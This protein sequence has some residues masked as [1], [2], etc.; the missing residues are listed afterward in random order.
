MRGDNAGKAWSA[1]E[2]AELK[3]MIAQRIS[4][5]DIGIALGR[6][7]GAIEA[8][9]ARAT[10]KRNRNSSLKAKRIQRRRSG[11]AFFLS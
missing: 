11:A 5:K 2:V 9:I 3:S 6:S 1:E 7:Q 8:Q 10:E 4:P